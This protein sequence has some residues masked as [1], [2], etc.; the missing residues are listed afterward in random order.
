MTTSS[1]SA[2]SRDINCVLI[3]GLKRKDNESA[4]IKLALQV[5]TGT[6]HIKRHKYCNKTKWSPKCA[7]VEQDDLVSLDEIE[8]AIEIQAVAV[9]SEHAG[10]RVRRGI[11]RGDD[12]ER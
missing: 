1:P 10:A 4:A 5:K 9:G 12:K 2:P 3:S 6:R 11:G 8:C 7:P